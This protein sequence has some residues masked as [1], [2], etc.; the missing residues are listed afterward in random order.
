MSNMHFA[1][2]TIFWSCGGLVAYAYAIYPA[3]IFLCSRI[4][5]KDPRPRDLDDVD[6]PAISLLI[7]AHN[8]EA[9]IEQRILNALAMDYP[10]NRL[11][12]VVASDGSDDRT[13]SILRRYTPR[14]R[15]LDYAFRRGKAATVNDAMT[16]ARGDI[17]I[18]SDANT[19]ID[20]SA[21]RNLVR[22]FLDPSVG[23]VC[24]RLVLVDPASGTNVDSLYWR[25]ET[26]LKRCES[27]LG[28]LLGAN[29]ALYS[30]RR[31]LFTPIPSQTIVD[32]FVIPLQAKL[33]T[34]KAI[35]YDTNAIAYEETAPHVADELRR[36]VRI[37]AG[38]FQAICMLWR[39]LDPRR[40]W[41]A[42]T[43]LS[44]KITRW[45]SP[46]FL[47]GMFLSSAALFNAGAIYR[48]SLLFQL[49]FYSASVAMIRLPSRI[50][51]L[52]PLRLTS[53]FTS[54]NAALFLGFFR[55][56]SGRQQGVWQRT[57]RSIELKCAA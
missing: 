1:L 8:E 51:F 36:R 29:G 45:L 28:A 50:R 57:E 18:L 27:K 52:R 24:G 49:V 32:D 26:F 20:P 38:G 9:V 6:L 41:I 2:K 42:F 44:H 10:T 12:I 33:R 40:G 46:F 43:F 39:L 25:Y 53:M 11:E 35:V 13:N 3:I 54:M 4:F 16:V 48:W 7:A 17:V 14:V 21:A 15:L 37:G 19:L 34:G 5:G 30:I 55:W 31:D 22:W 47:L 23:A 56:L